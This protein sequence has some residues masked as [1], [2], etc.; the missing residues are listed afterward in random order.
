MPKFLFCL[1][2]FFLALPLNLLAEEKTS[3]AEIDYQKQVAPI[4][5]KYCVGCHNAQD[6]EGELDLQTFAAIEKGGDSGP[7]IISGKGSESLLIQVLTGEADSVM[8]PEDNEAPSEKEIALLKAWIDSGAKGPAAGSET[9][10]LNV[11]EIQ[12]QHSYQEPITSMDWSDDGKWVAVA[13][14]KHVDILDARNLKPVRSLSQFPGKVNSVSFSKDSRHLVTGSGITGLQGEAAIWEVETGKQIKKFI[15]HQ[16]IVYTA[17]LNPAGTLVATG[18]YDRNVIL[19]DVE[20]G[21]Q[22]REL[23]G[24]NDAIYDLEFSPDGTLLVTAS[25][26]TTA[27]VWDVATGERFDTLGQPLKEVYSALFSPDGKTVLA[28]GVDNRIRVWELKSTDRVAINPLLYAQYAHLG[29]ILSLAYSPDQSSL[30]TI[31]EDLS[32]KQW[33]AKTVQQVH[34][35]EKQPALCTTLTISPDSKT[36]LVGRIDGTFQQY[37][38][39]PSTTSVEE[40]AGMGSK[41]PIYREVDDMQTVAE[42]EPNN[43]P[44]NATGIELPA[45]INGTIFHE[46]E[47]AGT[48]FDL[49]RFTAKKGEQW[50][51]E[52]KAARD[53]SPLDSKVEVLDSEG[54]QILRAQLKAVRDSYF[55][56]RGKDSFTSNDFRIHNWQEMEL[57]EY[58]YC[59][60]EIVK[61]WLYPRGPDSG[62]RVYPGEGNR[63]GYFDT[64]P[65]AHA[66]QEPCYIVEPYPADANV[67]AN[68]LPIFKLYYE[69]DDES[70]RKWGADSKLTF[71]AP[72]DGEYLVK[73][74]DVRG[75]QGS[76]F[77]YELTVRQPKPDFTVTLHG[78]NPK[79]KRGA[80]REIRFTVERHDNFEGPIEIKMTD[81]PP[82]MITSSP[83][84]LQEGQIEAFGTIYAPADVAA[85]TEENA[86]QAKVTATAIINNQEVTHEVNSLGEIKLEEGQPQVTIEILPHQG[87]L[88]KNP[89]DGIQEL[90]IHPGETV[91]ALIRIQRNGFD[92]RVEFGKEDSGRNLPYGVIVDNIGL[93]GLM[94]PE[95]QNEQIFF[96]TASKWLPEQTRLFHL[97]AN[98]EDGLTTLP[99]R[100]KVVRE[101]QVAQTE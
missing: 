4:L 79:L 38:L 65:L 31:S 57:D 48:D 92:N 1:A 95:G 83:I 86:K 72:A 13:S 85:L 91:S 16:D 67:V 63:Y 5:Q 69:N 45:K 15:G 34:V 75:F 41:T 47:K 21:E 93:N 58:L 61:L 100:L 64:T 73:V 59:N 54:N 10:T 11:P 24:H 70:L 71:T 50:I 101:N 8:P 60:G 7:A 46:E 36:F 9:I 52:I 80:G 81:L 27:K 74:S 44:E 66:L 17:R 89:E 25:G 90:T 20:S 32:I 78:A 6:R 49:Y 2:T 19:W 33:N 37:S 76:D 53:K 96:L 98:P 51:A 99:I 42:S 28:A 84:L 29:P 40:V 87:E 62:F 77:K 56:F 82:G 55:T 26:D 39:L 3:V 30:V 43:L 22:V 14:F 94:I 23:A 35:F 97:K 68:G 88:V 18:S 12:P